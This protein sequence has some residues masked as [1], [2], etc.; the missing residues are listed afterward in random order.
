MRERVLELTGIDN[1]FLFV[2]VAEFAG[3]KKRTKETSRS[4]VLIEL[5]VLK[6]S[7]KEREEIENIAEMFLHMTTYSREMRGVEKS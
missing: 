3:S 4:L 5:A 2:T 7:E 6:S 1:T